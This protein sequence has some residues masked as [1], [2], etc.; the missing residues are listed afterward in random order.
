VLT[1]TVGSGPVLEVTEFADFDA[2]Q[3]VYC[4]AGIGAFT[5]GWD[6]DHHY[7]QRADRATA[8]LQAG[9]VPAPAGAPPHPHTSAESAGR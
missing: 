8:I 6:P 2:G 9:P 3:A 7:I 4:V 5:L 1:F